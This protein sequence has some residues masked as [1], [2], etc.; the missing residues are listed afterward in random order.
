MLHVV[1]GIPP[2]QSQNLDPHCCLRKHIGLP[3]PPLALTS[4]QLLCLTSIGATLAILI[5]FSGLN[6]LMDAVSAG[7][8]AN[9]V[10]TR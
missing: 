9:M 4:A 2:A 8:M 6:S 10:G 3:H 7:A 5:I 1:Q